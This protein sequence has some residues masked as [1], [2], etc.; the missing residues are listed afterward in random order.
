LLDL[1]RGVVPAPRDVPRDHVLTAP[2]RLPPTDVLTRAPDVVDDLPRPDRLVARVTAPALVR[3]EATVVRDNDFCTSL[4][5]MRSCPSRCAATARLVVK[6]EV[7]DLYFALYFS[8]C[9]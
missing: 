4:D 1:T 8:G 5:A 6:D 3:D 2:E 9:V 7:S